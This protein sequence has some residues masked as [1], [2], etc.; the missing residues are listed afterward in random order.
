MCGKSTEVIK[1][2]LYYRFHYHNTNG[3]T[4]CSLRNVKVLTVIP[5]K[6]V[7]DDIFIVSGS[8]FSYSVPSWT[9]STKM[10]RHRLEAFHWMK[11]R[12]CFLHNL[13]LSYI[14]DISCCSLE[15][16]CFTSS[17]IPTLSI[18]KLTICYDGSCQAARNEALKHIRS[19]LI[20]TK[21]LSLE[22][23]KHAFATVKVPVQKRN[24]TCPTFYSQSGCFISEYHR[25]EQN[26]SPD[27]SVVYHH[28]YDKLLL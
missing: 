18:P 10:A 9:W 5:H 6:P 2:V 16:C 23:I 22:H 11:P 26:I 21:H 17:V 27:R 7:E 25:S 13:P 12:D 28:P 3:S 4:V 24:T 8:Y 20:Q 19:I 14:H 1:L 15:R